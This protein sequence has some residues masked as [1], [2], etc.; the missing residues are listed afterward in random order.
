MT[1]KDILIRTGGRTKINIFTVNRNE[2]YVLL[3]QGIVDD[4]DFENVPY[5]NYEVQYLT[6]I[7]DEDILQ[8][9]IDDYVG[10]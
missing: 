2:K 8:L 5:G 10:F 6:V 9:H 4:I 7:N 3:W 1:I